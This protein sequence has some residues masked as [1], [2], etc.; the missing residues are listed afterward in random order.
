VYRA[1]VIG[2]GRIGCGF[3]TDKLRGTTSTHAGSY[4]AVDG[5]E[6]VALCDNQEGLAQQY[7]ER[8][9]VPHAYTNHRAMLADLALDIVSVCTPLETHEEIVCDTSGQMSMKAIYCEKPMASSSS[10]AEHMIQACNANLTL[11]IINHQRRFG[12]LHQE[13]ARIIQSGEL[14]RIQQVTCYYGGGVYE[15]GSHLFDLLRFY[16]GEVRAVG[17]RHSYSSS[18]KPGDPSIDGWLE[19]VN[20]PWGIVTPVVIQACDCG[21]YAIFEIDILGTRGRLRV[22]EGGR[23]A[24]IAWATDSPTFTGIQE[25]SA[26]QDLPQSIPH[27]MPSMWIPRGIEHMLNCLKTGGVPISSGRDG[28]AALRII[29][30]LMVSARQ[31]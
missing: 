11:L 20:L 24:E 5:V 15:S 7:A 4:M 9:G 23:R 12:A 28:R 25:L 18:Y 21:A 27:G 16:L 8:L 29:E 17:A 31:K 14:G 19:F 2:C 30:A 1:G 6:L 26:P 3:S 22:V 13:V 10:A